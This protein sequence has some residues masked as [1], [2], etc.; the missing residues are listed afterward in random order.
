[1]FSIASAFAACPKFCSLVIELS[2]FG[3]LLL[4]DSGV[5]GFFVLN[6]VTKLAG[7][8]GQRTNTIQYMR[9]CGGSSPQTPA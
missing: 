4:R 1:M 7:F 9:E 3:S 6:I 5:D 2:D 8:G